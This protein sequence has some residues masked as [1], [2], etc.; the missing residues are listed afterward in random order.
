[1][2]GIPKKWGRVGHA[3]ATV[4]NVEA[5]P[6]GVGGIISQPPGRQLSAALQALPVRAATVNLPS[7]APEPLAEAVPVPQAAPPQR[8]ATGLELL[9][10][11]GKGRT[12]PVDSELTRATASGSTLSQAG[13]GRETYRLTGQT[14]AEVEKFLRTTLSNSR[15]ESPE[16]LRQRATS[17]LRYIESEK[18]LVLDTAEALTRP[19]SD[20]A[21]QAG[22]L[23]HLERGTW[24]VG[25][26]ADAENRED[27]SKLIRENALADESSPLAKRPVKMSEAV[28]PAVAMMVRGEKGPLTPE[29][30]RS[31]FEI[32]LVG[33]VLAM[34][35]GVDPERSRHASTRRHSASKSGTSQTK[36]VHGLRLDE[37][38]GTTLRDKAGLP[39][40]TG[41]SGS[42]SDVANAAL[43]GSVKLGGRWADPRLSESAAEKAMV[44]LAHHYMRS[45][46]SPLPHDVARRLNRIRDVQGLEPKEVDAPNVFTHTY[47]EVHAGISMSLA[48]SPPN[49]R[50]ALKQ[51]TRNSL[52]ELRR[53]S[54]DD[55]PTPS[56]SDETP[57]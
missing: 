52:R 1:M 11:K 40:M 46:D 53:M 17:Y 9:Q 35:L 4:S 38:L 24:G 47:A 18:K 57:E 6:R 19:D 20:E 51:V 25:A 8:R 23:A 27:L 39:V 56:D 15:Y 50:Q 37:D 29:Q 16:Q 21:M 33:H 48:S 54:G 28:R 14:P 2:E 55:H 22:W 41:T 10:K 42:A 36:N 44:H 12:W 43:Y 31:G 26:Q 5:S 34:R 30:T 45:E 3:P 13:I 7:T 32:A 49:D